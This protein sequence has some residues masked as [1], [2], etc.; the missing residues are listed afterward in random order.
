MLAP[1]AALEEKQGAWT[2]K[3]ADGRKVPVKVGQTSLTHAE[4]LEGLAEGDA[5]RL[6]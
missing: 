1:L 6:E 3:L 5:L 4:V 2:A